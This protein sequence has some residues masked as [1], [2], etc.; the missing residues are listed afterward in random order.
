MEKS[1][2]VLKDWDETLAVKCD[3]AD[4]NVIE[5]IDFDSFTFALQMI[6]NSITLHRILMALGK[7]E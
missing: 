5:L 3:L 6:F 4:A 1:E 7:D 2:L